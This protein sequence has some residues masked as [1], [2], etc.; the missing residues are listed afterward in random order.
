[1]PGLPA[2]ID[3][4]GGSAQFCLMFPRRILQRELEAMLD[5]LLFE[6][7][8]VTPTWTSRAGRLGR[9][10]TR[11]GERAEPAG[12]VRALDRRPAD[13]LPPGRAPRPGPPGPPVGRPAHLHGV[14]GR[15]P[16]GLP[17]PEPVRG[18]SPREVGGEAFG[19][20]AARVGA[21]GDGAH[22]CRTAVACA[23]RDRILRCSRGA[24]ASGGVHS[25]R[26]LAVARTG[27][28]PCGGDER[29]DGD[30]HRVDGAGCRRAGA[31]DPRGPRPGGAPRSG[32]DLRA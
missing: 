26:Q 13:A 21:S 22:R 31:A 7:I 25:V 20:T 30:D 28:E 3:W 4:H 23:H 8:G 12:R 15:R 17:L 5:R 16:V 1:M 10:W 29:C 19:D 6:P 27:A 24:G 18:G 32:L 14:P 11:R 9:G 2:V